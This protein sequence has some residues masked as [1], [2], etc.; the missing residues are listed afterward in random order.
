MLFTNVNLAKIANKIHSYLF[1]S[2]A[3]VEPS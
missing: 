3:T 1:I 2:G